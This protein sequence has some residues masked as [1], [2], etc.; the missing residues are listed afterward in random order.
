MFVTIR[1]WL[2]KRK[3]KEGRIVSRFI[4]RDVRRDIQI[5]S[6]DRIDEGVITARVRT[7]NVLYLSNKLIEEPVFGQPEEFSINEVWNWTGK[8]W[9]GLPDGSTIAD[10]GVDETLSERRNNT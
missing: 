6:T 3:Y 4:A 7:T 10:H 9:G 8:P 2:R 1:N 5:I